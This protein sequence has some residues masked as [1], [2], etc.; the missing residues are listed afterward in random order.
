MLIVAALLVM[1]D[2]YLCSYK[3]EA[4][5]TD[6]YDMLVRCVAQAVARL[7][8]NDS[9]LLKIKAHEIAINHRI[10]MYLERYFQLKDPKTK[11][12]VLSMDLEYNRVVPS[13][14]LA[15]K[16]TH[17]VLTF[18]Y[19][20]L[21]EKI[22]YLEKDV[23]PDIVVHERGSGH[24]N[25]L[26]IETKLGSDSAVCRD[27]RAKVFYACTQLGFEIGIALLINYPDRMLT[28]YMVVQEGV[29]TTYEF[30]MS[31]EEAV[32]LYKHEQYGDRPEPKNLNILFQR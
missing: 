31:D 17:T 5:Y 32:L 13:N 24:H 15:E 20:D 8:Q 11:R 1:A 19:Y 9:T 10:A 16:G 14:P 28:I 29:T 18:E 30:D 27:D 26:W 6:S 4:I 7:F 25:I 3:M 23:R 21:D 12:N 22:V 2:G